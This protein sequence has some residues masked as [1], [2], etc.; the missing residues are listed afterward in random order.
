MRRSPFGVKPKFSV[1]VSGSEALSARLVRVEDWGSIL[2]GEAYV[3]QHGLV[4]QQGVVET[5]T[6]DGSIA[7][8]VSSAAGARQLV[9]KAEDHELWIAPNHLQDAQPGST[10]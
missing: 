3:V 9:E 6:A 7:W 10:P 1:W 8:V 2:G 5:A 4:I